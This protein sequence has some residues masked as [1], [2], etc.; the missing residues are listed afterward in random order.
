MASRLFFGGRLYT[1]PTTV[2]QVTDTAMAPRNPATG[3]NVAIIGKAL[4]GKPNTPLWF[5]NPAEA[6]KVL[7]SGELLV[8]VRKAFAPSAQTGGPNRVC[9]IRVGSATQS[10]LALKDGS[11]AAVINLT[12]E[13]YGLPANG[14]R[15]KIEA[16]SLGATLK[17]ITTQLYDEYYI[18]DNVGR[19]AFTVKY[20]G[21][22]VAVTIDVTGT[23]V[24]LDVDAVDTVITLADYPTVQ[25]LCD[26]INTVAGF[27]ATPVSG[28]ELHKTANALDTVT[29]QDVKTAIYT[30]RADLQAI[31]DY[32]NSI[33][34][35]F[36]TAERVAAA[37]T[38]PANIGFTFLAGAT[39]PAV[40]TQ[41]WTTAIDVLETV[42]V[43]WFVPLSSEAG[44]HSAAD[45]HAV[46]MSGAGQKERRAVVGGAVGD[47]IATAVG[48]AKAL[49]SD[50][51][52]YVFPGHVDFDEDGNR[53]V[54]P[55]YMTAALIAGGMAG[56]NPGHALTNKTL[57]MVG[58]EVDVRNPVETDE[59][60]AAGVLC[61][62]NTERGYKVTRS[63][64]THLATD[65]F[66]RVELSCGAAA[67]FVVRSVRERLDFLRGRPNT[68]QLLHEAVATARSALVELARPEPA[69]PGVI[70]GD[71]NSPAF[72]DV[73]GRLEGDIVHVTFQCSPEVPNN[74]ITLGVNL[75]PYTGTA[76]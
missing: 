25:Q 18:K 7:R 9:A 5:Q 35:P 21:A 47:T 2:S 54:L 64:S 33:A 76:A 14:V 48:N 56:M 45:A 52:A 57:R 28:S 22:A 12:S 49:A 3:N 23:T 75:V 73:A 62:E 36:V 59:L 41:D 61:V 46:F 29:A 43:Q 38:L 20:T 60:I 8:A 6:E 70:V 24:T 74:F 42:D 26:K 55:A 10:T 53:V 1:S 44:V 37:G 13:V 39:D 67:D 4:A 32:F 27:A 15:V 11:D 19:A 68:P 66:N 72:R 51:T 31:V 17:K 40:V 65:N 30:V 63:I 16:G 50:R 69:G 34:E 71:E 58:L